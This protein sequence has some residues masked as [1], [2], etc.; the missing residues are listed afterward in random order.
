MQLPHETCGQELA[1]SAVV[2]E[3]F[4]ALFRH[5]AVNLREHAVWVGDTSAEAK[6]EQNALIEVALGYEA[7]SAHALHTA[8][9]MRTLTDLPMVAHDPDRLDRHGFFDWMTT[10]LELQ[11]RLAQLLLEHAEQSQRALQDLGYDGVAAPAR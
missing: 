1:A 3:Q 11:R 6:R 5:V 2:P 10:K 9:L 7:T 4:A 8:R